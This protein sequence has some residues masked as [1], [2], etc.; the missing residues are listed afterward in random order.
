MPSA[1]PATGPYHIDVFSSWIFPYS[2][3]SF[4][5]CV[6]FFYIPDHSSSSCLLTTD[7]YAAAV[8]SGW[9]YILIAQQFVASMPFLKDGFKINSD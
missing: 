6:V 3:C 2:Q 7:T 5:G 9:L 8:V 1:P 4:G